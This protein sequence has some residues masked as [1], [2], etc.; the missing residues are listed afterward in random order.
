M[1]EEFIP[2]PSIITG[3]IIAGLTV[4]AILAYLNRRQLFVIVPRLFSYSEVSSG[5]IIELT[6]L[7]RGRK[8][9][10]DVEVQLSPELS[11]TVI[12]TTLPSLELTDQGFIQLR[13]LA[14]GEDVSIVLS[15]E[16]GEF[17]Q[18]SVLSITSKETKGEVKNKIEESQEVPP[19]AAAGAFAF[20]FIF[21]PVIGYFFGNVFVDEIWPDIHPKTKIE[22]VVSERLE[23]S[24]WEDIDEY[25]QALD[26]SSENSEWP[27]VVSFPSR[28]GDLLKFKVDINN[29]LKSRAEF[30]VSLSTAFD[31]NVY[32]RRTGDWP[33]SIESGILLL[34]NEHTKRTLEAYIPYKASTKLVVFDFSVETP[35]NRY[36]FKYVWQYEGRK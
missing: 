18:E 10:E 23:K 19:A 27:I 32:L 2:S 20:I 29:K 9:E 14:K 13:R 6:I 7:N 4:A 35:D 21:M 36:S 26:F 17:T 31:S 3:S 11:Y 1:L 16:G 12:A 5:Q 34:P 33:N 22:R 28:S 8:T 30:R 25:L 24:G 15:A